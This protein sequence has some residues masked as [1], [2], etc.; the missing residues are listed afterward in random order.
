MWENECMAAFATE[1]FMKS[2]MHTSA[3]VALAGLLCAC[4]TTPSTKS[5][6]RSASKIRGIAIQPPGLPEQ[7]SVQTLGDT[8][9]RFSFASFPGMGDDNA[10]GRAAAA[11]ELQDIFAKANYDYKKDLRESLQSA[12]SK[13]GLPTIAVRGE[14]PLKKRG[15]FLDECPPVPGA[16]TCLDVFVT[17]VGFTA[18]DAATDY[19]PT[20]EMKAKLI[21]I[22]DNAT[23]FQDQIVYNAAAGTP[24]ILAQT[25]GKYK[26]RDRDAMKA[27]PQ[28]VTAAVQEAVKSVATTLAKQFQ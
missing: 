23:L 13:S 1:E 16:D 8:E 27:N 11:R 25:S 24:G 6:V 9:T 26:F 19:V 17:Y 3:L 4:A 22:A 28:A 21:R 7:P 12:F 5:Y 2:V 15:K 18:A 20:V 14:R 10:E